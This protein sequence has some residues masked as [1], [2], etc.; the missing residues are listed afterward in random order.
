MFSND[1]IRRNGVRTPMLILGAVM[2][3]VYFALGTFLLL[4]PD[5]LPDIPAEFRNV[6]AVL[7]LIYGTY[8]GWRAYADYY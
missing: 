7:L 5:Y 4:K 8:R 1:R 6:L 3:L 2:T